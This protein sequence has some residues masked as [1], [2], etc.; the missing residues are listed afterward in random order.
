MYVHSGNFKIMLRAGGSSL[1]PW[2]CACVSMCTRARVCMCVCMC[3]CACVRVYVCVCLVFVHV[4]G[5]DITQTVCLLPLACMIPEKTYQPGTG[6]NS[7]CRLVGNGRYTTQCPLHQ[8]YHT[9]R[10]IGMEGYS[11]Q[12]AKCTGFEKAPASA[13]I[14]A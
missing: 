9:C 8:L 12:R 13:K 14:N 7:L 6:N 3:V 10:Q 11:L 5:L 2:M 4:L 1:L